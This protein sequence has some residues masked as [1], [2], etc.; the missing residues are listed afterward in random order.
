MDAVLGISTAQH[1]TAQ[2]S[3]AQHSTAQHSTA[4]H[5]TVQHDHHTVA[6]CS[7]AWVPPCHLLCLA[8]ACMHGVRVL[9][10]AMAFV[11]QQ[12]F[13]RFELQHESSMNFALN[14]FRRP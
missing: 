5:S 11:K 13:G 2:H 12:V 4:Q 3:T 9:G 6:T 14:P 10:N 8:Y 7:V 1:S